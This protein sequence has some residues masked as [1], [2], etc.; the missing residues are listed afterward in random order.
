MMKRDDLIDKI[1]Q[2]LGR[3]V[4]RTVD[5]QLMLEILGVLKEN[6]GKY[7]AEIVDDSGN[8]YDKNDWV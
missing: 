7:P 6:W 3:F 4:G 2:D 1:D 8:V 5:G